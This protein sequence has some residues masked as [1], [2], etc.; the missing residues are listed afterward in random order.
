MRRPNP[1]LALL[2]M[3]VCVASGYPSSHELAAGAPERATKWPTKTIQIS[4]SSSLSSYAPGIKQGSDVAGAIKRAMESW[5]SVANI[6]LVTVASNK[7]SIS[8]MSGGDGISLITIASTPENLAV[9]NG[10]NNT[11]RTRMFYDVESGAITEADIVINPFPYSPDGTLLQFSTDGSRGTYDLESTLAHE[12]GHL[13]GLG[14]SNVIGATMQ[15]TQGLN[16][17]YGLAADTE[18]SLSDVDLVAIRNVYGPCENQ[19]QVEGRILNSNDGRLLSVEAAHVWLEDSVSGR[20]VASGRTDSSGAFRIGCIPPA[21]YRA[22]IEYLDGPMPDPMALTGVGDFKG[23]VGRRA[24]RSVEINNQLRISADKTTPLNYIFVPPQSTQ[25]LVN[26][27]FLG[28]NGELSTTPIPANGGT[29]V[30]L[31]VTGEGVDQVPGSG[32]SV[33]SPFITVDAASLA[34]QRYPNSP[35]MITFEVTVGANA[36]PGDYSLRFQSN[37]GEVAYLVGAITVSP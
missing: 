4:I 17:T 14:H 7:Q 16:G 2:A 27:R 28:A 12:I 21:T 8:P 18:R 23:G 25:P 13:L 5:A 9:F 24:F 19:G 1:F 36:P 34:L 30:T 3:L 11:A 10:A 22:M 37:S 6:S 20:V 29:K 15:P 35:S 31:F 26:P 32:L 33:S